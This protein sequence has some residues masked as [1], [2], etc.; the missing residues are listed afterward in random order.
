MYLVALLG[1]FI[2]QVRV[3]YLVDNRYL[4]VEE[5]CIQ[6]V[7]RYFTVIACILTGYQYSLGS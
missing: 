5:V 6:M 3:I 4:L 7:L 1:T 2:F